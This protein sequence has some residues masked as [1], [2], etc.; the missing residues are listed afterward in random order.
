MLCF[1]FQKHTLREEREKP[2]LQRKEE[3]TVE[4]RD[5][6][7]QRRAGQRQRE[8]GGVVGRRGEGSSGAHRRTTHASRGDRM[9]RAGTT[10]LK[11]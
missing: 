11:G 7:G 1:S 5:G 4:G 2:D 3:Q 10:G 9:A 6:Q 8:M